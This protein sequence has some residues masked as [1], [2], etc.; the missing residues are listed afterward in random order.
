MH[1]LTK[2]RRE[3]RELRLLLLGLENAG[4]TSI[5]K[6]FDDEGLG[7][8]PTQGFNIKSLQ[9]E[10]VRLNVWDIGGQQAI[11]PFWSNYFENT[12]A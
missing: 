1:I 12:D 3:E 4:K 2:M 7:L 5:L 11:R 9:H 6:N 10:G 8:M